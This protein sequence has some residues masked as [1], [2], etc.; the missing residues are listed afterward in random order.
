MAREPRAPRPQ[1]SGSRR[2]ELGIKMRERHAGRFPFF[3]GHTLEMPGTPETFSRGNANSPCCLFFIRKKSPVSSEGDSCHRKKWQKIGQQSQV[4]VSRCVS[5]GYIITGSQ[6][7]SRS[8]GR[9]WKDIFWAGGSWEGGKVHYHSSFKQRPLETFVKSFLK[10][11]VLRRWQ[12]FLEMKQK[13]FQ[14]M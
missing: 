13:K 1:L 14:A 9:K 3:P 4:D 2:K 11:V 8:P 6:P 5:C 10:G 7:S 12:C